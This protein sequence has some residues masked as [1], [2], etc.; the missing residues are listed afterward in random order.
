[1][2]GR[3]FALVASLFLA[4]GPGAAA[5]QGP[6]QSV[7][8]ARPLRAA[9]PKFAPDERR[10]LDGREA[11]I[12]KSPFSGKAPLVLFSHGFGGCET[13]SSFLMKQLAEA[14]YYV[15]AVRHRD[16]SCA[17]GAPLGGPQ[18]PFERPELWSA[19]TYADRRDD[20]V[21]AL[22]ALKADPALAGS[23]DF[24]KIGLVGHSLGGYTVLGL[25]GAWPEWKM[26]GVKAT[27]ALSPYCTPFVKAGTLSAVAHAQFQGGTKDE[28]ITPF[29]KA[30]G[31][32]F[33][34][35]AKPAMFVEF[36]GAGHYAWT[37]INPAYQNAIE[38]YAQ[39]FLDSRLIGGTA[40][41]KK[42]PGVSEIRMK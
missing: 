19:A 6:V 5:A 24:G 27:V 15:V 9:K 16:A 38:T 17:S 14:G 3:A 10:T 7:S 26:D 39:S 8:D 18:Q 33:D 22:A 2:V 1:M 13:Q 34:Q 28:W 23:V 32:C 42:Q 25:A 36:D 31:G 11:A 29:V 35:T 4:A 40:L 30:P 20:M 21:A 41:N 12:W 37:D